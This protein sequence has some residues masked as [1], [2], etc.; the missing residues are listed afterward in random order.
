[1]V[2][3]VLGVVLVAIVVFWAM[4]TKPSTVKAPAGSST[5]TSNGSISINPSSTTTTSGSMN[6]TPSGNSIAVGEPNPSAPG[7]INNPSEQPNTPSQPQPSG[8]IVTITGTGICLPHKNPGEIQTMEC[9]LG[10]K[11]DNGGNY[12][13]NLDGLPGGAPAAD[14]QT[15]THYKLT[16][17]MVPLDMIKADD[18]MLKYDIKGRLAVTK[19]EQM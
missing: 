15:G 16:G 17:I 5:E 1:M 9:A 6:I 4:M 8:D 18:P 19:L 7:G 3:I 14:F 11:A 2:L 13:L 10:L 12:A